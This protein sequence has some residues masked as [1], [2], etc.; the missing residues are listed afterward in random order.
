MNKLF[1]WFGQLQGKSAERVCKEWHSWWIGWAE[2]VCLSIPARFPITAYAKEEMEE[3]EHYYHVGR[4]IGIITIVV[5]VKVVF[6]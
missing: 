4:A 6:F 2:M 3:E 5:L 1:K